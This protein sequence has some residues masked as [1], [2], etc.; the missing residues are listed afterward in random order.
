MNENAY[1]LVSVVTPCYNGES[2]VDRFFE[3]V[4]TQTYPRIEMIFVDDGSTDRTLE[5]AQSYVGAF[6]KRGY[7][8][9]I[10]TQENAGQACALNLGFEWVSGKYITWPDCDDLMDPRN[11]EKKASFLETHLDK[12]FVLCA[13]AR[14]RE[15]DLSKIISVNRLSSYALENGLFDAL[16]KENGAFCSG[17]AYMA[18]AS[19]LFE[20]IGGKRIFESRSGQNWQ[21]LF[22]LSYSYEFGYIDETLA[23]YVIRKDSHSRS[24]V[25][26][27]ERLRRTYEL[28]DIIRHTLP[29]IPM[30]EED[31]TK[32]GAYVDVKYA[33][34]RFKLALELGNRKLAREMSSLLDS[35]FGK[36]PL[37]SMILAVFEAGNGSIVQ[38]TTKALSAA[39]RA[40]KIA[41]SIARR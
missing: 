18:R 2:F 30:T 29:G 12:G 3:Q 4:L 22:P 28:E 32:Y 11:I 15:D 26:P 10:L 9:K 1:P 38:V 13:V 25:S 34:A 21:L 31:A 33:S 19:V 17:I 24:Y 16:I 35:T 5:I 7:S 6:E 37:R 39:R 14:V 23:T 36:S 20:A 41:L 8:L 40:K 27:D